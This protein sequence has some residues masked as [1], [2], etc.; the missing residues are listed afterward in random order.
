M[1]KIKYL[2]FAMM[3][4]VLF[5]I[6][7]NVSAKPAYETK[8]EKTIKSYAKK[9][10]GAKGILIVGECGA[11]KKNLT[12]AKKAKKDLVVRVRVKLLDQFGGC[13]STDKEKGYVIDGVRDDWKPG[14]KATI[15]F[16]YKWKSKKYDRPFYAY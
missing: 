7:N 11:T 2:L 3:F 8:M 16:V 12:K 4:L 5:G 1:K 15:Y 6:P 9:K 10:H 13:I 14:A